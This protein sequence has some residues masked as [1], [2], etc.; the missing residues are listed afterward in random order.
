MSTMTPKII[1]FSMDVGEAPK[2]HDAET[3]GIAFF[4]D[5]CNALVKY[6][7]YNPMCFF[8]KNLKFKICIN[9]KMKGKKS[10]YVIM[11]IKNITQQVK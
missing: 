1:M 8:I 9:V 10:L 2:G 6:Y 7:K 4:S 11:K 5:I 3:E